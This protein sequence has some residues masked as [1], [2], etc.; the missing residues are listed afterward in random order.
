MTGRLEDKVALITGKGGG[1]GRAAAE[2][3][4]A[5]GGEGRRL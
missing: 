5:E 2:R 3:F 1:Q 4:A